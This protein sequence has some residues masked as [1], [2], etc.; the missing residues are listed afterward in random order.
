M[1]NS[2]EYEKLKE[3]IEKNKHDNDLMKSSFIKIISKFIQED[4][5]TLDSL[6][7]KKIQM[8]FYQV[9]SDWYGYFKLHGL[10]SYE[11]RCIYNILNFYHC[12]I[13]EPYNYNTLTS[14][15]SDELKIKIL[16][17]DFDIYT[18]ALK[19][20]HLYVMENMIKILS[21][22]DYEGNGIKYLELAKQ[23]VNENYDDE[24]WQQLVKTIFIKYYKRK[25]MIRISL[26]FFV[27]EINN[28][29]EHID[30]MVDNNLM[31][32]AI[33]Y[34]LH[35]IKDN[36]FVKKIINLDKVIDFYMKNEND[37]HSLILTFVIDNNLE[38]LKIFVKNTSII[39][40]KEKDD[41]L[42][43]LHHAHYHKN[44]DMIDFLINY[45]N[46][47]I[48]ENYEKTKFLSGLSPSYQK[49]NMGYVNITYKFDGDNIILN[50]TYNTV[51]S[52]NINKNYN[53]QY[54]LRSRIVTGMK[55]MATTNTYYT[56]PLSTSWINYIK[57][58]CSEKAY[59]AFD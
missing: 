9:C 38:L 49:N 53:N 55:T 2:I 11:P 58:D 33:L 34:Q 51:D 36:E 23:H 35:H 4:N 44:D 21:N 15:E 56:I 19:N 42:S 57:T 6:L 41:T 43:L 12:L 31:T 39:L 46:A 16:A 27:K 17:W 22:I 30:K 20:N 45:E 10:F 37:R 7:N 3:E 50:L 54:T 29:A 5:L 24:K 26:D 47:N 13:N 1:V 8:I 32:C 52:F 28:L 14:I 59:S 40:F 18:Q 48:I 25:F